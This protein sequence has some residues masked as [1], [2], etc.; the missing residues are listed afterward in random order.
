MDEDVL[1]NDAMS[2]RFLV[3]LFEWV[4][5]R[6]IDCSKCVHENVS[7]LEGATHDFHVLIQTIPRSSES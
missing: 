1:P 6:A 4:V 5:A 7:N 3:G 2:L